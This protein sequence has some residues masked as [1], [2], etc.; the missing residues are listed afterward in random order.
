MYVCTLL[1]RVL[2]AAASAGNNIVI[3]FPSEN[4]RRFFEKLFKTYQS[5]K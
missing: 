4:K 2:L 5:P 3:A 1:S